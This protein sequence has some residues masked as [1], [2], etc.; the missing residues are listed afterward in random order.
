MAF[1]RVVVG[2]DGS[3]SAQ[4]ALRWAVQEAA[5]RRA[6]VFVVTAVHPEDLVAGR[7]RIERMQ[8]DAIAWALIDVPEPPVV[9]REIIV[10]DPV[11]AICHAASIADVVV[12]GSDEFDGLLPTSLAARVAVRLSERRQYGANVPLVVVPTEPATAQR[13]PAP[14][15]DL[16]GSA[17]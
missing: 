10:A 6:A 15:A 11:M 7:R 5:R 9:G 2:L 12:L 1:N 8:R 16:V 3:A 13:R 14:Q 17:A 4:C